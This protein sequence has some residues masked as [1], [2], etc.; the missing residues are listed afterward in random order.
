MTDAHQWVAAVVDSI[1]DERLLEPA[2]EEWTGK[3]LLAHMA[4]WQDHSASVIESLRAGRE[5]HDRKDPANTTDALNRR[6]YEEH[7]Q[8]SPAAVRGAFDESFR[9]LLRALEPVTEEELFGPDRWPWL[10][11]EPLVEMVLWDTSRH[12]DAHRE[13]LE[14]LS[15]AD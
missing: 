4:W 3:D 10:D 14:R 8:D 2:T 11:G 9:R 5:P 7:R 12:Y 13:H 6:V 15:G 1:P